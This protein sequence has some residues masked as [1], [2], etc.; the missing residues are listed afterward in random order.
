MQRSGPTRRIRER[1]QRTC[2]Q[3]QLSCIIPSRR[4]T[5]QPSALHRADTPELGE[6]R[7]Q[8]L[9]ANCRAA[10]LHNAAAPRACACSQ[11]SSKTGCTALK[12]PVRGRELQPRETLVSSVSYSINTPGLLSPHASSPAHAGDRKSPYAK[13]HITHNVAIP[14][15]PIASVPRDICCSTAQQGNKGVYCFKSGEKP[16]CMDVKVIYWK[17]AAV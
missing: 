14:T 17:K 9:G 10:C 7:L 1:L 3:R 2:V 11:H 5:K 6:Q 12:R 4:M 16:Q 13:E 8:L 15:S